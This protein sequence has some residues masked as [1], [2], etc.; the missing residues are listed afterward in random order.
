MDEHGRDGLQGPQGPARHRGPQ[1]QR[2]GLGPPHGRPDSPV[3][4]EGLLRGR[5]RPA[6]GLRQGLLRG[7]HLGQ[8][9]QRQALPGGLDEQL[10]LRARP[11]HHHL[12]HRHVDGA[13]DGT[14]P[15][16]RQ[17]APDRSARHR[18]GV[19]AH[20]PGAHPEGHRHPGGRHLPRPG[21]SGHLPG[22]QR[23]PEPR[24]LLLRRSQ[25]PR[26]RRAVHAHRLRLPGQAARRG[27]HP[28]RGHRL[29]P[30][31]PGPVHRAAVTGQQGTGPPA[32]HC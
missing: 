2:R 23:G 17:A 5:R 6:P 8:R 32:H 12:A 22:H 15:G 14:D 20:R 3:G 30:E 27:P 1:R 19:P 7:R 13:R 25:S 11:A 9:P 4:H 29:L 16:G 18:P 26:Q 10:G 24:R 28:L 21:R 31:V